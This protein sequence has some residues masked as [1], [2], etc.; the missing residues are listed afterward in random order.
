MRIPPVVG[1]TRER[2]LKGD[3]FSVVECGRFD[4]QLDPCVLRD[5]RY[6]RWWLRP[7][8]WV[9]A[10]NEA[11]VLRRL[12]GIPNVPQLVRWR[13]GA[14]IRTWIHGRPLVEGAPP[15]TRF[16]R[17]GIRLLATLHR[18]GVVHNDLAKQPNWLVTTTGEAALVDFQVA[19]THRRRSVIF[20]WLAREDIRH[21]LKHKRTYFPDR[22]T[23]R[24]D[25]IESTRSL[26]H[27][28]ILKLWKPIYHLVTRRILGW[29]DREGAQDRNYLRESQQPPR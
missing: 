10:N 21:M 17:T 25:R 15:D 18:R 26:P 6:A 29:R 8:A 11:R 14:L 9:L 2:V 13:G 7:V 5:I 16:F 28:L 20:R 23:E 24:E 27:R 4:G 1:W 3:L 22:L 12:V 19:T